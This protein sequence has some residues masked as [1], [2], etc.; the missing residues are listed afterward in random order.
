MKRKTTSQSNI[1][2]I[3]IDNDQADEIEIRHSLKTDTFETLWPTELTKLK[4]WN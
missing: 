3:V 2:L 1:Q 4:T